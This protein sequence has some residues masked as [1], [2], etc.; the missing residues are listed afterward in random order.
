MNA[1]TSEY[2]AVQREAEGDRS[3]KLAQQ[4]KLKKLL[5]AAIQRNKN[6]EAT[7]QSQMIKIQKE[8]GLKLDG[9][10]KSANDAISKMKA[11]QDRMAATIRDLEEELKEAKKDE[12]DDP[13]LVIELE[14]TVDNLKRK[15]KVIR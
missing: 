1:I 12:D 11:E 13:G 2:M 8:Y 15:K 6:L 14:R 5:D 3:A 7:Y 9:V 10:S 4:R